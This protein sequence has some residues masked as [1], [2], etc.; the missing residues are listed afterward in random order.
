MSVKITVT[1]DA[2]HPGPASVGRFWAWS[3]FL[4]NIMPLIYRPQPTFVIKVPNK[5][6]WIFNAVNCLLSWRCVLWGN[7]R[8]ISYTKHLAF[9]ETPDLQLQLYFLCPHS[10]SV[11]TLLL[12]IYWAVMKWQMIYWEPKTVFQRRTFLSFGARLLPASSNCRGNA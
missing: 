9:I 1:H 10:L 11:K 5:C 8:V 6:D 3:F 2:D 12:I 4:I 7:L